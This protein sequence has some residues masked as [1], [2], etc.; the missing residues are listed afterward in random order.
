LVIGGNGQA[1]D[2]R[3]DVAKE[4]DRRHNRHPS[5]DRAVVRWKQPELALV[6]RNGNHG[7]K[8]DEEKTNEAES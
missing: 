5:S 6:D 2:D 8:E 4:F 7:E 1:D 3:N